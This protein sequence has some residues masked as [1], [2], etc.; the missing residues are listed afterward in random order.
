M[1]KK[2]IATTL[3]AIMLTT[4]CADNK[5]LPVGTNGSSVEVRSYGI[6]DKEDEKQEC[7]NYSLAWGNI[8]WSSLLV[9]TVAAPIYFVGFSLYEPDSVDQECLANKE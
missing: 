6:I 8:V 4:G 1:F 3:V 7:V 9:Y 5:N 2:A